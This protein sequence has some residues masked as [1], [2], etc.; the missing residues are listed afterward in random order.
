MFQKQTLGDGMRAGMSAPDFPFISISGS[1]TFERATLRRK[2][3]ENI[4][5]SIA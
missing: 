1:I 3:M 4:E 5:S 2:K